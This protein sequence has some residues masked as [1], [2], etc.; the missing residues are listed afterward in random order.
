M[1]PIV[2]ALLWIVGSMLLVSSSA[3]LVLKSYVK[4]HK[5]ERHAHVPFLKIII[6]TGPQKEALKTAY[7]AELIGLSADR[8][9]ATDSFDKER[10][11][12]QLLESPVIQSAE[13]K[14]VGSDTLYV[15]YTVRQPLA[16]VADIENGGVDKEGRLFPMNPFF[17]PKNL[18][19]IYLGLHSRGMQKTYWGSA[20]YDRYFELA[21]RLL[22]LLTEPTYRDFFLVKSIDVSY[23]F[24]DSLG[25]REI[26][27]MTE[28]QVIRGKKGEETVYVFP[29]LLRLTTKNYPQELGNYLKLREKMLSEESE[30]LREAKPGIVLLPEKT[31]DLRISQLAFIE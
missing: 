3:H 4:N 6:Q 13:V 11:K 15:D 21:L 1:V 5:K 16:W 7:L 28:D 12:K 23:A 22:E 17:T 8:P 14:V 29:R 18:P 25:K 19:R 9:I 27:V 20:L 31:I 30:L 10:A 24:E 2:T 26:V